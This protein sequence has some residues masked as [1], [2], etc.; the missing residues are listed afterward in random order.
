[1]VAFRGP[2]E[3]AIIVDRV[4]EP[5]GTVTN[6]IVVTGST[7]TSSAEGLIGVAVPA[8][9]IQVAGPDAANL[10]RAPKVLAT[11]PTG[12]ENGMVVRDP[13]LTDGTALAQVA[14][15]GTAGAPAAGVVTVQGIP[16]GTPIPVS[17][18]ISATNPSVGL[19]G[20]AVPTSATFSGAE[21]G[22]GNL[23]GVEARTAAP[24]GTE[25][26][27]ITRNIPSGTQAISAASLPLPT[28]A[29]TAALQTQ[30]GVDIGDVT[31]NNGAGAA[32]VNIQDGGNS[33]TV[34]AVTLPLPTGAATEATLAGVLTT[35]AFQ[36]RIN[37][38]GQNTMANS[39]PVV[40]PSDQSAI[41]VSPAGT[42]ATVAIVPGSIAVFT[43]LAANTARKGAAFWNDTGRNLFIKMGAA[44]SLTSY[45]VR[46]S[47]NGY[48]EVPFNYT[49][50][51][52]AICSGAGVPNNVNATEFT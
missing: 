2:D 37:V 48:Y 46:V 43:L 35:A 18:T 47:N 41:P 39:T 49:G 7:T 32:A 30:P 19:T 15:T 42:S 10:L 45:T 24:A 16:G 13:G 52:T 4:G 33:I 14:G 3:A 17:G 26:G 51:I 44:A 36:A 23:V 22:S 6:P 5:V 29:A 31:V 25:R 40:L 12:T 8:Y 1:M 34:D 20:A 28:G 21:D 9:G 38:L 27:L 50:I 11:T